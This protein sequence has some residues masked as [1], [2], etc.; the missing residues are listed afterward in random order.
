MVS[1][2]PKTRISGCKKASPSTPSSAP[3]AKA[4]KKAVETNRQALS[5]SFCPRRREIM[6]P[7]PMARVKP[8]AWISDCTENTTPTAAEAEVPNWDTKKVSVML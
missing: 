7:L 2:E 4:I 3:K 5:R 8:T 1:V 6:L